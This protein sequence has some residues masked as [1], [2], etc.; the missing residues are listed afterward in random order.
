MR[1]TLLLL[2]LFALTACGSSQE[3]T[4]TTTPTETPRA[5]RRDRTPRDPQT[6]A[7]RQT[8]KMRADL[9]L[10]DAQTQQVSAINLRYAERGQQLRNQAG[11]DRRATMQAARAL[12]T[13]RNAELKEVLTAEQYAQLENIQARE[14]ERR[15]AQMQQRR[16]A[17]GG[18]G[19]PGGF[20]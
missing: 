15:R 16:G 20:N 6:V 4:T 5:E 7:Q 9:G 13:D 19:R 1:Y 10:S 8:E 3:A 12:Q 17:R 2:S 14:Q 11:G 18:A